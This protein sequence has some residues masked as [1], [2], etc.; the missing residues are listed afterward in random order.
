MF[1]E[2]IVII[3]VIIIIT[4]TNTINKFAG[5]CVFEWHDVSIAC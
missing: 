2:I 3:V 4:N 1:T 5:F